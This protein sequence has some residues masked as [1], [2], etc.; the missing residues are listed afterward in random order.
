MSWGYNGRSIETDLQE[1]ECNLVN[2][3]KAQSNGDFEAS[4]EYDALTEA[5]NQEH[6]D[7]AAA[8]SNVRYAGFTDAVASAEAPR[9]PPAAVPQR[10]RRKQELSWRSADMDANPPEAHSR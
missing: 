10:L 5:D 1:N 7:A 8:H 4:Y 3:F 2:I 6:R 9:N